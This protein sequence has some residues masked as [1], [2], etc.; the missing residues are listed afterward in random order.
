MTMAEYRERFSRQYAEFIR[1]FI[2]T[3]AEAATRNFGHSQYDGDATADVTAEVEGASGRIVAT[4]EGISFIEFGA[5]IEAG[6]TGQTPVEAP[7][8]IRPGSWSEEHAQQFSKYG[9]WYHKGKRYYSQTPTGAMQDASIE[10]QQNIR[11]IAR[12]NFG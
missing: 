3:G 1:D 6:T 12:R 9:Y 8:E 7:Y 10:M 5:G 2:E 4:G 11:Q